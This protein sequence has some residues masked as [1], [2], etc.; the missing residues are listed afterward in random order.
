MSILGKESDETY[1]LAAMIANLRLAVKPASRWQQYGK[2]FQDDL[3]KAKEMNPDNP[4]IYLLLGNSNMYKPKM[5]GG[6]K[7]AAL[8]Y[9]EKAEG[10][11]AKENMSDITKPYWGKNQNEY[12]LQECKKEDKE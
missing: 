2:I 12:H 9:Y 10:L 7:K 1:V 8:P 4:R 11:F 6:G 5:F 3:D